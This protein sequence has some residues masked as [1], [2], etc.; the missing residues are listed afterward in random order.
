MPK[1]A[2]LEPRQLL[3]GAGRSIARLIDHP[4]LTG[5]ADVTSTP[6]QVAGLAAA[7]GGH[8]IAVAIRDG[9]GRVRVVEARTPRFSEAS[10][11]LRVYRGLADLGDIA[12]P[13]GLTWQ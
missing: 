7:P 1:V 2:W 9:G 6:G 13:V 3:V 8:R 4:G 5:G 12:G 11:P 10:F